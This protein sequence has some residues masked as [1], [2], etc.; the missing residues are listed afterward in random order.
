[1]LQNYTKSD[2]VK[3]DAGALVDI[4]LTEQTLQS[5]VIAS[6]NAKLTSIESELGGKVS[7]SRKKSLQSQKSRHT[8]FLKAF[9]GERMDEKSSASKATTPEQL[10]DRITESH[11]EIVKI[12]NKRSKK[13]TLEWFKE[14]QKIKSLQSRI[15]VS[16]KAIRK[17]K[18]NG[19]S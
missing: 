7:D 13:E 17:M 2:L 5:N 10:H 15:S 3:M 9:K 6:V 12:Q 11:A 1:M 14:G 8:K 4:I 19:T 18:E 16:K